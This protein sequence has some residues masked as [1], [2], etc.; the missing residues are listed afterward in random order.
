M[1][2]EITNKNQAK[3]K[4][5]REDVFNILKMSVLQI[6]EYKPEYI[7]QYLQ[8]NYGFL[9][10][11]LLDKGF[12]FESIQEK[13][14]AGQFDSDYLDLVVITLRKKTEVK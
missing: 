8:D 2:I 14:G 10:N 4:L 1:I 12:E 5:N 11:E 9:V 7:S 13:I 6:H 3:I